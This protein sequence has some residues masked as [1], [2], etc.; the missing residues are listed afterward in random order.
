MLAGGR[1]SGRGAWCGPSGPGPAFLPFIL[2]AMGKGFSGLT[3]ARRKSGANTTRGTR[4]GHTQDPGGC[5]GTGGHSAWGSGGPGS[6]FVR[7]PGR[8][9]RPAASPCRAD[10][11]VAGKVTGLE[12]VVSAWR[13]SRGYWLV[14]KTVSCQ[15]RGPGEPRAWQAGANVTPKDMLSTGGSLPLGSDSVFPCT[16]ALPL[17]G[18]D[19]TQ[20]HREERETGSD[21]KARMALGGRPARLPP[22]AHLYSPK[23]SSFIGRASESTWVSSLSFTGDTQR[24]PVFFSHPSLFLNTGPHPQGGD[25]SEVHLLHSKSPQHCLGSSQ[26]PISFPGYTIHPTWA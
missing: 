16:P 11:G 3:H 10:R 26:K 22:P 21:M 17:Q 18:P 1:R 2:N 13:R 19:V 7:E 4:L 20:Q 25:T 14:L 23:V 9:A 5:D 12:A 6:L 8:G 15:T 24:G